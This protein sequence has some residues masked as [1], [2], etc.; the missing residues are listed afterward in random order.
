MGETKLCSREFNYSFNFPHLVDRFVVDADGCPG[1]LALFWTSDINI[2]VVLYSCSHI[3]T[4]I[5]NLDGIPT[6]P[7]VN[8][9]GQ[10]IITKRWKIWELINNIWNRSDLPLII[11]TD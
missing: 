3:D 8:I 1:G 2:S 10:P 6:W 7:F 4:N 9:Y 11:G 5:L